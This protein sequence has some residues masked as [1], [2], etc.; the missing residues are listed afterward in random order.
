MLSWLKSKFK[1]HTQS[2]AAIVFADICRSTQIFETYGDV[3]AREI[4]SQAISVLMNE[5][6]RHGGE[7]VKTIG[8]EVMSTFA[9]PE[10]AVRAAAEMQKSIN[11][12]PVLTQNEIAVK[13]GLH[14]GDVLVENNDVFG[15]AVNVAARMVSLAKAKQI[16]TTSSTVGSVSSLLR[17]Y[18]RDLGPAKVRGKQE[19][20]NISEVIWQEDTSDLTMLPGD[21][22]PS[23]K[24]SF[25]STNSKLLIH[26]R[27]NRSEISAD[28][29][30]FSMGREENNSLFIGEE[31]ASRNHAAIECRQGKFVL[32]DRSTNGTYVWMENGEKFFIHREEIH[33]YGQGVISLGRDLTQNNPELIFYKHL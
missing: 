32:V 28:V 17:S 23:M 7:V 2:T 13:I 4:L 6:T 9:D 20:I 22:M 30:S 26:Y 5:T 8:D 15:D 19:Q 33:L 25:N 21:D 14:Y 1:Q 11:Q 3:R 29:P 16:I 18:T 31:L 27:G 12:H 24:Q 10:N